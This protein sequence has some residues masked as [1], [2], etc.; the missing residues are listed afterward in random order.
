MLHLALVLL[1]LQGSPPVPVTDHYELGM[2]RTGDVT[3]FS[4]T[5][6]PLDRVSCGHLKSEPAAD[7]SPNPRTMSFDD[8]ADAAKECRLDVTT[9]VLSLPLGIGYRA[10]LRAVTSGGVL[11]AWDYTTVT[12]RRAPRGQPCPGG[13]PGVLIQGEADLNGS[14]VSMAICVQH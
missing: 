4:L 9:P 7:G 3:P 8:P 6:Y 1:L 11:S 14:V 13:L 2:F 12:F 5:Q 10:A